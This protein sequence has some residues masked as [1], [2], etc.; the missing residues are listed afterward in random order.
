MLITGF[1]VMVP[2]A[3]GVGTVPVGTLLRMMIGRKSFQGVFVVVVVAVGVAVGVGLIVDVG[4]TVGVTVGVA[5]GVDVTVGVDVVV[6]VSVAVA[7]GVSV[8]GP[9][10]SGLALPAC[11]MNQSQVNNKRPAITENVNGQRLGGCACI[12]ISTVV[13]KSGPCASGEPLYIAAKDAI[14]NT[15]DENQIPLKKRRVWRKLYHPTSCIPL[16]KPLE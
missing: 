5:V 2:V 9:W 16:D 11:G 10:G 12:R 1:G 3:V 7:V 15:Q 6:D 14:L 13:T 8:A 4:V